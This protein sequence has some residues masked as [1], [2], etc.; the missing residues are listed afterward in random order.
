MRPVHTIVTTAALTTCCL[1]LLVQQDPLYELEQ[2]FNAAEDDPDDGR[3]HRDDF[4]GRRK[5]L[6]QVCEKYQDVLRPEYLSLYSQD[7]LLHNISTSYFIASERQFSGR[8][9]VEHFE[10]KKSVANVN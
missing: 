5:H 1:L 9:L 4:A 8:S 3:G 2:N 7:N 10:F 6:D